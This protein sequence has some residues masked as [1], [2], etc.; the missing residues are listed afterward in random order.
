MKPKMYAYPVA[1][2]KLDEFVL[3]E[4]KPSKFQRAYLLFKSHLAMLACMDFDLGNHTEHEC[5]SFAWEAAEVGIRGYGDAAM[6]G[7]VINM[8]TNVNDKQANA[9]ERALYGAFDAADKAT[10]PDVQRRYQPLWR[11]GPIRRPEQGFPPQ[12]TKPTYTPY[13]RDWQAKDAVGNAIAKQETWL[14]A[15]EGIVRRAPKKK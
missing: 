1:E 9:F 10:H 5:M 8:W 13:G 14:R 6:S 12:E 15:S 7:H 2:S 4:A 11:T 3:H